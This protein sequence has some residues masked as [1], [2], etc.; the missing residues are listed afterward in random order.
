MFPE[1]TLALSQTQLALLLLRRKGKVRIETS[2]HEATA[3]VAGVSVRGRN[4][5]EAVEGLYDKFFPFEE[6]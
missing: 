6:A 4:I 5:A 1:A 2:K 3:S